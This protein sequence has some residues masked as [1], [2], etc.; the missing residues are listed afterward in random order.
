M[1]P[2]KER[3]DAQTTSAD[4]RYSASARRSGRH[5]GGGDRNHTTQI[6]PWTYGCQAFWSEDS[7][8]E[9]VIVQPT[10]LDLP[11][12]ARKCA[13]RTQGSSRGRFQLVHMGSSIRDEEVAWYLDLPRLLELVQVCAAG[14]DAS[15]RWQAVP[16]LKKGLLPGFRIGGLAAFD[17]SRGVFSF[18][19]KHIFP[20]RHFTVED[21]FRGEP[22]GSLEGLLRQ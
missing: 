2:G 8:S 1:P 15:G 3:H 16:G 9:H 17:A 13:R 6:D 4:G 10:L 14:C 7:L 18:I 19:D 20:I 11:L 21:G 12:R 5:G 22:G